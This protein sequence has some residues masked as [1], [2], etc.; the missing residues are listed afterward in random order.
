MK[1]KKFEYFIIIGILVFS[2]IVLGIYLI[3]SSIKKNGIYSI[4]VNKSYIECY[5]WKCENKDFIG[6]YEGEYKV[7]IGGNNYGVNKVKYNLG[8]NKLYIFDSLNNSIYKDL[9]KKVFIYNGKVSIK[10]YN[11]N[12]NSD[13]DNEIINLIEDNIDFTISNYKYAYEID[14]DFDNDGKFEKLVA[15]TNSETAFSVLAYINDSKVQIIES[16]NNEDYTEVPSLYIENIIDI[17]EDGKLEFIL[18]KSFYDNIGECSMLYRLKKNKF[19]ALNVCD[20]KNN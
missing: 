12:L 19:K 10:Q 3:F 7:Y 5:R 16:Y 17:Y 15:V 2:L 18:N 11:F 4:F 8:N 6:N 13:V 9:S 14:I 1:N 20:L